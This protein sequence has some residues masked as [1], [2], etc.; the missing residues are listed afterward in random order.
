MVDQMTTTAWMMWKWNAA[1]CICLWQIFVVVIIVVIIVVI[2]LLF[3]HYIADLRK[4]YNQLLVS[5]TQYFL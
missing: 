5:G 1:E 2:L 4:G 3:V